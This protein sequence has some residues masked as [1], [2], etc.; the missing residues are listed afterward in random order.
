MQKRGSIVTTQPGDGSIY[1]DETVNL[2]RNKIGKIRGLLN[3]D[4]HS[5]CKAFRELR[6]RKRTVDGVPRNSTCLISMRIS[7][8]KITAVID[9]QVQKRDL[10]V[11]FLSNVQSQIRRCASNVES[12]GG[13]FVKLFQTP[14]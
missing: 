7:R 4:H 12:L 5:P 13:T 2:G 9:A 10:K 3:R 6:E 1:G 14:T 8:E 11:F